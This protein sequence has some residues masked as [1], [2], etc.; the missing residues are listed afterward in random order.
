MKWSKFENEP[1]KPCFC[2]GRHRRGLILHLDVLHRVVHVLLLRVR[3]HVLVLRGRL[4][5]PPRKSQL[6]VVVAVDD[7]D[8][9]QNALM[10]SCL[11]D[12]DELH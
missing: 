1:T 2:A 3:R 11:F 5:P 9:N 8:D 4:I 6:F 12:D 10:M 7:D